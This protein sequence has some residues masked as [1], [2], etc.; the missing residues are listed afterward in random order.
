M[1]MIVKGLR[2]DAIIVR[3]VRFI[4]RVHFSLIVLIELID[5]LVNRDLI[6]ELE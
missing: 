3:K 1:A 6:F 4:V 2:I 5:L